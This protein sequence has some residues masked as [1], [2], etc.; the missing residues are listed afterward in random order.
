MASSYQEILIFINAGSTILMFFWPCKLSHL[1][2][3]TIEKFQFHRKI[4]EMRD[5]FHRDFCS[6]NAFVSVNKCVCVCVYA[7][8]MHHD[9]YV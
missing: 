3:F 1:N 8:C 7:M 4:S 9:V 2:R 6:K 5:R